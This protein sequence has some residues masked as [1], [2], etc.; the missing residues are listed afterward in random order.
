MAQ[1]MMRCESNQKSLVL[2]CWDGTTRLLAIPAAMTSM[3]ARLAEA[4]KRLWDMQT[5]GHQKNVQKIPKP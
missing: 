5:M 1:L 2:Q 3:F 4:S